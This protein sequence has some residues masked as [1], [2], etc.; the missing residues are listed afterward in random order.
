MR[1]SPLRQPTSWCLVE[2]GQINTKNSTTLQAQPLWALSSL[3]LTRAVAPSLSCQKYIRDC[4]INAAITIHCDNWAS[5]TPIPYNKE[6]EVK[7]AENV[8][9]AD[10]AP[11]ASTERSSTKE[12]TK[13]CTV[14]RNSNFGS[15]VG[16]FLIVTKTTIPLTT[17]NNNMTTMMMA[18]IA[19]KKRGTSV[20]AMYNAKNKTRP[21]STTV[22]LQKTTCDATPQ[23]WRLLSVLTAA[24][25][26]QES[27]QRHQTK[28][29][30]KKN[31]S[32][33]N[34]T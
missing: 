18:V 32:Q 15:D 9:T 11:S 34:C 12:R 33:S 4:K 31:L 6:K 2:H 21:S 5:T 22:T 16:M 13:S 19:P 25:A 29:L 10:T 20:E 3:V 17:L 7:T 26:A 30:Q 23:P 28:Y 24:W 1:R 8:D 14:V 27:R